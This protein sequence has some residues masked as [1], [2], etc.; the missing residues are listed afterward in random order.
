MQASKANEIRQ[1]RRGSDIKS[2]SEMLADHVEEESERKL[3]CEAR[4]YEYVPIPFIEEVVEEDGSGR[5]QLQTTGTRGST[6]RH[7]Q[8]LVSEARK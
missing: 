3:K 7:V 2:S 4:G 1:Q 6:E 8:R 5:L